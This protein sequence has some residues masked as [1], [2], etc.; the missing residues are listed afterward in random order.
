M[1]SQG[2][3][4]R[5]IIEED[6]PPPAPEAVPASWDASNQTAT[7]HERWQAKQKAKH[8]RAA[9][10]KALRQSQ[11][12]TCLPFTPAGL[13]LAPIR[14]TKREEV[15]VWICFCNSPL[16]SSTLDKAT[17]EGAFRARFMRPLVP[18]AGQQ[19]HGTPLFEGE[20]CIAGR[21]VAE[22]ATKVWSAQNQS[23]R[24]Q[25]PNLAPFAFSLY[26]AALQNSKAL[27]EVDG[28]VGAALQKTRTMALMV[29]LD[30]PVG[31]ACDVALAIPARIAREDTRKLKDVEYVTGMAIAHLETFFHERGKAQKIQDLQGEANG[32]SSGYRVG[33]VGPVP[34]SLHDPRTTSDLIVNAGIDEWRKNAGT[35]VNG[36]WRPLY[37]L[38]DVDHYVKRQKTERE[39]FLKDHVLPLANMHVAWMKGDPI[40]NTFE[41]HHDPKALQSGY[42]GDMATCLM[43]TQAWDPCYKLYLEWL[44]DQNSLLMRALANG[45]DELLQTAL[46]EGRNATEGAP[47]HEDVKTL[48][49][50]PMD[51][52]MTAV[53]KATS[54]EVEQAV[55]R[56][57]QAIGGPLSHL[58][59]Q[60]LEH[61][62][63]HLSVTLILMHG[64]MR[65][66]F[67]ILEYP[68]VWAETLNR[69]CT[70]V[71]MGRNAQ[72]LN[73]GAP[74]GAAGPVASI[75]CFEPD[76][77]MAIKSGRPPQ[78]TTPDAA[79]EH[80]VSIQNQ[81]LEGAPGGNLAFLT[82]AG[83]L[84]FAAVALTMEKL[85]NTMSVDS[86]WETPTRL[87][88]G[89]LALTG[90][91]TDGWKAM[92]ERLFP[93]ALTEA[94]ANGPRTLSFLRRVGA[95]QWLGF[96]GGL[97]NAVVD[98]IK[99]KTAF[100]ENNTGLSVL[101]ATSA[102]SGLGAS[103]LLTFFAELSWVPIW[104]PILL[105]IAF[106]ANVVISLLETSAIQKW[107][108]KTPWADRSLEENKETPY[109][110][111]DT[112]MRDLEC[113]L[114]IHKASPE[115]MRATLESQCP[116]PWFAQ[117]SFQVTLSSHA[118]KK[119]PWPKSRTPQPG[120]RFPTWFS[121]C[122]C[123]R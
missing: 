61:L 45:S 105:L 64:W 49:S 16:A 119:Y 93:A 66:G 1:D 7:G 106:G 18:G 39:T 120:E 13:I 42:A 19:P 4:T 67:R 122:H 51:N 85:G 23:E 53:E 59:K 100:R 14:N 76:E 118:M 99:A 108:M 91:L 94:G 31:V 102:V 20:T 57:M 22:H 113:A 75:R 114:G 56:L 55:T 86:P 88:A 33:Q 48:L 41:C 9:K 65:K 68:R 2:G 36:Q 10:L 26:P 62:A 43:G 112:A 115:E 96:A 34:T 84:Q 69:F 28:D 73:P 38:V 27:F 95:G 82:G 121:L 15:K 72:A 8:A 103:V 78:W 25:D 3:L 30:D 21:H 104:G 90:T 111:S 40:R 37:R 74:A 92:Q 123:G 54:P 32:L 83:I 116:N 80:M 52:L 63:E 58:S 81:A 70:K 110:D 35:K 47:G 60:S 29:A 117:G 98:F 17:Q 109:T 11:E 87:A 50:L 12:Q 77:P 89:I 107:Y 24:K 97:I 6:A 71:G 44:Q 46:Q 5:H 101:Y 79:A